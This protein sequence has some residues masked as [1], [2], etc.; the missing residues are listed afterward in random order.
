MELLN[1]HIINFGKL[2]NLDVD[3]KKGLNSF[4]HENGWGK[5]TLSVFIKAMFYGFEQ[6]TS[7]DADKNEKLKYLPWQGGI[8]GGNLSFSHNGKNYRITRT[9]SMKAK[10]ES[11][12]ILDLSTNKPSSDFTS[13]LGNELFGI[14]R[15]TY[16]RSLHVVL[17][18][19]LKL[20]ILLTS[21]ILQLPLQ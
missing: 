4:I 8:Y 20:R 11:F 16:G 15:E 14:N 21:S 6:T 9:F 13:D 2:S 17:T 10:E 5:T 18:F 3:F 1:A 19:F 12:E 7:K